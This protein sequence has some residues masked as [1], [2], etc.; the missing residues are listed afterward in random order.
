MTGI[1]AALRP[2]LV[3]AVLRVAFLATQ[4]DRA[5]SSARPSPPKSDRPLVVVSGN[6]HGFIRPCGC[7]KPVLGG[8][9]RRAHAIAELKKTEPKLAAV[10]VGEFL[11]E[12]NE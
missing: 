7:S 9:H 8:V 3:V 1:A 10:S 11:N 4:D 12:T 5:A 2:A 6:E